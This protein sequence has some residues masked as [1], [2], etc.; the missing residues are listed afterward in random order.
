MRP[1]A[2]SLKLKTLND[3][4]YF[5][6]RN[7][8]FVPIREHLNKSFCSFRTDK[9]GDDQS[10]YED[11]TVNRNEYMIILA[12]IVRYLKIESQFVF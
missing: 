7:I 5:R 6:W 12:G 1:V 10:I 4:P 8:Y 9:W 11:R 2:A 3:N